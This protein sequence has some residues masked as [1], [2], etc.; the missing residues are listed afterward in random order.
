M[1]TSFIFKILDLMAIFYAIILYLCYADLSQFSGECL[2]NKISTL[3][4]SSNLSHKML[5]TNLHLLPNTKVYGWYKSVPRLYDNTAH[6]CMA[7][8]AVTFL[9]DSQ[10]VECLL[11]DFLCLRSL[12]SKS[13]LLMRFV[14]LNDQKWKLIQQLYIM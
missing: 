4:M 5:F 12:R 1:W 14:H 6:K 10:K 7:Y 8:H 11:F 2:V 9:C 13:L 3:K